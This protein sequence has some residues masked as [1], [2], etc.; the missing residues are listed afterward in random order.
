MNN[1]RYLPVLPPLRKRAAWAMV[2]EIL[3][4]IIITWYKS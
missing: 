2:K 1:C 4:G 3:S